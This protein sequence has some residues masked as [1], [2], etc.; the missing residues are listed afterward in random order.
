MHDIRLEVANQGRHLARFPTKIKGSDPCSNAMSG[1]EK[2]FTANCGADAAPEIS[3]KA[4]IARLARRPCKRSKRKWKLNDASPRYFVGCARVG[5]DNRH[6][7]TARDEVRD[8][9]LGYGTACVSDVADMH[10]ARPKSISGSHRYYRDNAR[11]AIAIFRKA[12]PNSCCR[13]STRHLQF[14]VSASYFNWILI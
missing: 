14:R 10:G 4:W 6:L 3:A 5:A 11:M 12:S 1:A 8:P 2:A 13:D 9:V 7:H